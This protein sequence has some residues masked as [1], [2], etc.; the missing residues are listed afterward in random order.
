MEPR[1]GGESVHGRILHSDMDTVRMQEFGG[2]ALRTDRRRVCG[3]LIDRGAEGALSLAPGTALETADSALGTSAT[4]QVQL[5]HF[6]VFPFIYVSIDL[7][8]ERTSLYTKINNGEEGVPRSPLNIS[9][10]L[11]SQTHTIISSLIL[12]RNSF[13]TLWVKLSSS[14]RAI[15]LSPSFSPDAVCPV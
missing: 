10:L 2:S 1:G 9:E 6:Y 7:R 5:R 11:T 4:G 14:D 12:Y 15:A 8:Q 3:A 13:L